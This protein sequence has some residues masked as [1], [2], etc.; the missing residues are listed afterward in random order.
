MRWNIFWFGDTFWRQLS[1]TAMGTPPAC[2]Y[3][4][5]YF[6]IHKLSMPAAFQTCLILYKRYIDDGIDIWTGSNIQWLAFQ[7][8]IN[9]FGT[10]CWTFTKPSRKIDYLDLA[11]RLDDTMTIRTSLFEKPLNLYLY[12]PPHSA[13]P[14]GALT[15]L[16]Y[17][18]IRRVFCLTSD[19]ANCH[20]YLCKFYTRL[21]YRG[22]SKQALLLLFEAGLANRTKP[23]RKKTDQ[24]NALTLFLH[25][26]FHP[27][28]PLS[29]L[30]QDTYHDLLA[31]PKAATPL[32]QIANTH[33]GINCGIQ[34]MIIAYHRPPN[35]AN[36]LCPR[37]FE[38]TPGPPVLAFVRRDSE[39][40]FSYC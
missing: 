28:N 24:S 35:L 37:K 18:T 36:L 20:A 1:G 17:G 11:I 10:L 8:W 13:H 29:R 2:V 16:I 22:Y 3:A 21:C 19:P 26:P 14:P 9:S 6:A 40:H 23:P 38:R 34:K 12:P 4:T 30:L 32:P 33:F 39:G 7:K 25:I 31:F 5:I 15:G 27:T